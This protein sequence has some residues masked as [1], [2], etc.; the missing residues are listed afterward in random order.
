M[1]ADIHMYIEYSTKKQTKTDRP[2][3]WY[4]FGGRINPGR[5]YTMF[6]LLAGVRG[7][8]KE[9]LT[10]K[11]KLGRDELGYA[12]AND[13]Y[14]FITDIKCDCGESNMVT[15]DHALK[16][17][18]YGNEIVYSDGKP[19]YVSHPDWHSHSWLTADELSIVFDNYKRI[20]EAE[21][22]CGPIEVPIEYQAILQVLRTLENDGENDSRVVF[23]FDN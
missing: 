8:Y 11:G 16:Y 15:L 19:L 23:W 4:T 2:K 1:G 17:T 7:S 3:Y 20:Y 12:S 13:L 21:W 14:C 18:K 9:S 5:N 6:S 10:P 22:G